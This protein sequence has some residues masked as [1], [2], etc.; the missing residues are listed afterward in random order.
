MICV[1]YNTGL[2]KSISKL[3]Y[4]LTAIDRVAERSKIGDSFEKEGQKTD[5]VT[6]QEDNKC[7]SVFKRQAGLRGVGA[8]FFLCSILVFAYR[9]GW[10]TNLIRDN[11]PFTPKFSKHNNLLRSIK[12]KPR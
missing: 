3:F 9:G 2:R 7:S 12:N 8:C 6:D 10:N 11:P 1:S 5:D 4:S